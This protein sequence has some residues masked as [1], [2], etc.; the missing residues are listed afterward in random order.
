MG[1]KFATH[2]KQRTQ[3]AFKNGVLRRTFG[4]KARVQTLMELRN[5][6]YSSGSI[7]IT[8]GEGCSGQGMQLSQ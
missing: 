7:S 8:I 2:M 6:Y 3:T 1:V 5:L 4:E